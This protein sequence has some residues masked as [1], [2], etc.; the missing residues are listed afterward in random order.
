MTPDPALLIDPFDDPLSNLK[1]FPNVPLK[2]LFPLVVPDSYPTI[3][4]AI[5]AANFGD[6]VH[7]KPGTYN[8][9]LTFKQGVTLEGENL[10]STIVR[11]SAP[12]TGTPL[13]DHFDAPLYVVGCKSGMVRNLTFT[14]DQADSP[15]RQK[16]FTRPTQSSSLTLLLQSRIVEQRAWLQMALAFTDHSLRPSLWITSASQINE[17]A[18]TSVPERS[19]R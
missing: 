18:S 6:T 9:A 17:T 7:V 5:D 11:Y 13:Q 3:Q 16:I 8:E 15:Q 1:P 14:Q 2:H 19:A 12:P 10:E 4:K